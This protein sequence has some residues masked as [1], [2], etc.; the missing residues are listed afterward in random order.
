M[1]PAYDRDAHERVVFAL[2]PPA[3]IGFSGY[4]MSERWGDRPP[5][6]RSPLNRLVAAAAILAASLLAGCGGGG[7]SATV[8]EAQKEA[9]EAAA[10]K[11]IDCKEVKA[12]PEKATKVQSQ[13]LA[14]IVRAAPTAEPSLEAIATA[15]TEA[16]ER[17]KPQD[18]AYQQAIFLAALN[19]GLERGTVERLQRE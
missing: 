2:V 1:A 10:V 5:R 13:V 15:V 9:R 6:T 18:R 11:R 16:C 12:S 19:L 14:G 17:A 3:P 8:D 7:K 4:S